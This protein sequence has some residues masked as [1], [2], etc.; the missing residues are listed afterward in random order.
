MLLIIF[1]RV[2]GRWGRLW[3]QLACVVGLVVSNGFQTRTVL[4][5]Q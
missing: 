2:L 5:L 1:S 3:S 4:D